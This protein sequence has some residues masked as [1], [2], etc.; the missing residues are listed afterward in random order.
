MCNLRANHEKCVTY[1]SLLGKGGKK[2]ENFKKGISLKTCVTEIQCNGVDQINVV[3]DT[4][5]I[6]LFFTT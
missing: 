6:G 1:A 5:N 4:G 3:Q 2:V